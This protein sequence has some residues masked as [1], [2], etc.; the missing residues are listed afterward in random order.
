MA[1]CLLFTLVAFNHDKDNGW[2]VMVTAGAV[3]ALVLLPGAMDAALAIRE[4][5]HSYRVALSLL[6]IAFVSGATGINLATAAGAMGMLT[7]VYVVAL[8][9]LRQGVTPFPWR[10]P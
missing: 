9:V 10:R 7:L 4:Q 1:G 2:L 5:P 3:V 8:A 6:G